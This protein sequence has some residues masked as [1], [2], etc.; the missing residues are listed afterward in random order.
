MKLNK[1]KIF[2]ILIVI[3][4]ILINYEFNQ[5]EIFTIGNLD[6]YRDFLIN[7]VDRYWILSI[8]IYVL[9]YILVIILALPGVA[10]MTF[11]G[12]VL[13]PFRYA[14]GL[15][16]FASIIGAL[17]NFV[18]GRYFFKDFFK[19]TFNKS[20]TKINKRIET[21]S[22]RNLL[23]LRSIPIFPYAM[24]N[25]AFAISD[26]SMIKFFLVTIVG[27]IPGTL[28]IIYAGMNLAEVDNA[29]DLYS[30]QVIFAIV[31]LLAFITLPIFYKIFSRK[32]S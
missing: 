2:G 3:L 5:R 13:F 16:M 6:Y 19:R 26:I 29:K 8:I 1:K 27:K 17:I 9:T 31:L 21:G 22:L 23:I 20:I 14:F 7:F 18:T 32:N 25:Y 15:I 10:V 4:T 11:T 24:V 28:I 30:P 12:G